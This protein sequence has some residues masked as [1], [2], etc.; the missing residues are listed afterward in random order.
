MKAEKEQKHNVAFGGEKRKLQNQSQHQ[1]R[2]T[3]SHCAVLLTLVATVEDTWKSVGAF[4]VEKGGDREYQEE[5]DQQ[6][7]QK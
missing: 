5:A 7:S 2:V 1:K 6:R 3:V 4:E